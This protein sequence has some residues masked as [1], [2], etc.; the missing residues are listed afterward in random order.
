MTGGFGINLD[1]DVS[2]SQESEEEKSDMEEKAEAMTEEPEK[3]S[4]D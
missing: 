3:N 4:E 1:D 2:T